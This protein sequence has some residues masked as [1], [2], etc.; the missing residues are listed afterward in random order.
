MI[1]EEIR[2]PVDWYSIKVNSKLTLYANVKQNLACLAPVFHMHQTK[3][4]VKDMLG[5]EID[6]KTLENQI[7]KVKKQINLSDCKEKPIDG[8]VSNQETVWNQQIQTEHQRMF[9]ELQ[10]K[11]TSFK[12]RMQDADNQGL[13]QVKGLHSDCFSLLQQVSGQFFQCIP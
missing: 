10:T 7:Q 12:Q 13:S 3:M 11:L 6:I 5:Q 8:A 2:L 4:I 1:L 9:D